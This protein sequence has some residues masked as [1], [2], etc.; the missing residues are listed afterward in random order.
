MAFCSQLIRSFLIFSALLMINSA[1]ADEVSL[2]KKT[3][4][5]NGKALM[6]IP[7]S[8]NSVTN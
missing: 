6:I 7:V 5:L 2:L 1:N 8:T 4:P 3:N